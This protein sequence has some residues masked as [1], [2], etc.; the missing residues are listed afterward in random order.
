MLLKDGHRSVNMY[1]VNSKAI[2]KTPKKNRYSWYTKRG[3]KMKSCKC[4]IKIKTREG[5]KIKE[6]INKE[7][8]QWMEHGCKHVRY[9]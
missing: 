5:R 2:I 9:E 4:S 6:K 8:L 1:I 7:Q 3:G